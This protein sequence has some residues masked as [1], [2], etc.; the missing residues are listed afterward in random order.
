MCMC[1]CMYRRMRA[2]SP[3]S[4]AP[5]DVHVRVHVHVQAEARLFA[6]ELRAEGRGRRMSLKT[7]KLAEAPRS[8]RQ[9]LLL[10]DYYD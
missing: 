7:R 10:H 8:H 2:C 4:C 5:R 6:K 3:P 9:I 1:M